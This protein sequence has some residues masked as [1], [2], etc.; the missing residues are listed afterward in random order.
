MKPGHA[1]R[2]CRLQLMSLRIQI[3][4]DGCRTCV[5]LLDGRKKRVLHAHH[6]QNRKRDLADRLISVFPYLNRI[7][8]LN[9]DCI[10]KQQDACHYQ[11]VR[12]QPF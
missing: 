7:L 9:Y 5:C 2:K 11:A 1:F 6:S 3:L 12:H 10:Q 4:E 8:L